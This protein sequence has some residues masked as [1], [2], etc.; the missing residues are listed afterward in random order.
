M[1]SLACSC[2]PVVDCQNFGLII[3]DRLSRYAA[4]LYIDLKKVVVTRMPNG[5]VE[6]E[7]E[8]YPKIFI[9]E[10]SAQGCTVSEPKAAKLAL[11]LCCCA[12]GSATMEGSV[13]RC[14]SCCARATAVSTAIATKG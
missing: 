3:T 1:A 13:C 9:G 14:P 2:M 5:E 7:E 4:P 12:I 6:E 8:E 10:V 11:R